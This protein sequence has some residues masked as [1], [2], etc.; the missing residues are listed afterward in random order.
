[1]SA[2]RVDPARVGGLTVA[3]KIAV[4]AELRGVA[5]V[6]VR[7]PELGAHLGA[8]V[9]YGRVCEYVDWFAGVFAGGP[10]FAD[11]QLVV[12]DGPGLGLTVRDDVAA[13]YRV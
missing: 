6:P 2:V 8:G 3:R 11:G 9:M 12:P 4:A 10:Q 13:K 5:T 7:L 1:M